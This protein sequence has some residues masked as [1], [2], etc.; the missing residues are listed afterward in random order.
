MS[1]YKAVRSSLDIS[2]SIVFYLE[3]FDPAAFRQGERARS[4]KTINDILQGRSEKSVEK[5]LAELAQKADSCSAKEVTSIREDIQD[6]LQQKELLSQVYDNSASQFRAYRGHVGHPM[7]V[8]DQKIFD[9]MAIQG[10]PA[11]FFRE[12]YFDEVRIYCLPEYADFC[13]SMLQNCTFAV[14]RI[15]APSF[16]GTSIYNSEFHSCMLEYGNFFGASL[17]H[18]RFRDSTLSH[19]TF[20]SARL[21]SCNTI[22]CVLDHINYLNATLDGCSFGRVT[23]SNIRNLPFATITQG[24]ATREE[25]QQNREAIFRALGVE[26][27]AA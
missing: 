21:K 1:D 27:E 20:Q 17:A 14:C 25:C 22:D 13:G 15:S 23:P 18:T 9:R 3:M 8:V 6:F 11:D 24:G 12:T 26:E 10:F 5:L 7:K 19:A 2:K 16:E 4:V